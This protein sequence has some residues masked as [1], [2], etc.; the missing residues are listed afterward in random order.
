MPLRNLYLRLFNGRAIVPRDGDANIPDVTLGPYPFVHQ[1]GEDRLLL[2]DV[3][4]LHYVHGQVYYDCALFSD[5]MTFCGEPEEKEWFDP[6][7]ARPLRR[8]NDR[9]MEA[10]GP[11]HVEHQ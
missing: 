10:R 1:K 5:W 8:R 7:K 4:R 3:D 2:G 9:P 6:E 11:A